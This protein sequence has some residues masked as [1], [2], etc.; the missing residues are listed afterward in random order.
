M[1]CPECRGELVKMSGFYNEPEGGLYHGD[2]WKCECG[3]R[4]G[5]GHEEKV[6]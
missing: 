5:R 3:Y 1:K 4:V 2:F 6:R